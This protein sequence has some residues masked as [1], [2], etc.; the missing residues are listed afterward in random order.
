MNYLFYFEISQYSIHLRYIKLKA[1]TKNQFVFFFSS[2]SYPVE[3]ELGI[4]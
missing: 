2:S 1:A 3:W 4:I